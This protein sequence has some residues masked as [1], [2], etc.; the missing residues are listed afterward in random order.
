MELPC[1]VAAMASAASAQFARR[2]S[3]P[4]FRGQESWN[5][6]DADSPTPTVHVPKAAA[7]S[8]E[9]VEDLDMRRLSAEMIDAALLEARDLSKSAVR[10]LPGDFTEWVTGSELIY[11]PE[12][13]F[14]LCAMPQVSSTAWKHLALRLAGSRHWDAVDQETIH[15]PTKSGLRVLG[16][17]RGGN[18]KIAEERDPDELRR[19]FLND[20]VFKVAIVRDP[21]TR[22]LSA[23]LHHCRGKQEWS[24][25]LSERPVSFQQT[26]RN[27]ETRPV[28]ADGTDSDVDAHFRNQT[29]FCGLR[30]MGFSRYSMIAKYENLEAGSRA[31]LR[32][33]GLWRTFGMTGWGQKGQG[34]FAVGRSQKHGAESLVCGYYNPR[35]LRRV[36]RLYHLDFTTFNYTIDHWMDQCG[37]SSRA[38]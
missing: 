14:V 23:Y 25:C 29:S 33:M 37:W 8:M 31:F 22:L 35:L 20:T 30:Y 32:H 7:L 24:A 28:Q 18:P 12:H 6:Q 5:W 36:H 16:M 15:S 38:T 27:Y 9:A 10:Q 21:V 19:V 3:Q 4:P 34:P 11:V 17:E 26:V 1:H 13:S 2:R